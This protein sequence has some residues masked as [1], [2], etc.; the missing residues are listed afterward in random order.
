MIA[1]VVAVCVL[2]GFAGVAALNSWFAHRDGEPAKHLPVF[3]TMFGAGLV[4][5][6]AFAVELGLAEESWEKSSETPIASAFEPPI[7]VSD[8]GEFVT[9]YTKDSEP[10]ASHAQDGG[11]S[12]WTERFTDGVL[13][14][15]SH[16]AVDAEDVV[17]ADAPPERARAVVETCS[18]DS[19]WASGYDCGTRTV[20]HVPG[21]GR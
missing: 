21:G 1:V 15:V 13:T 12:Y 9:F 6:A 16:V 19:M 7:S 14:G 8:G 18:L 5:V 4:L 2:T 11:V 20:L 17:F 3:V 10:T